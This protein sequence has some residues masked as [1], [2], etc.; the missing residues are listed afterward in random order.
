MQGILHFHN[1]IQSII[2]EFP[3]E[4]TGPASWWVWWRFRLSSGR[5]RR[6]DKRS[7]AFLSFFKHFN[8]GN[9]DH[10]SNRDTTTNTD[11]D[12]LRR[13]KGTERP[14]PGKMELPGSAWASPPLSPPASNVE[15][16]GAPPDE[17]II[18]F[19][20]L[21][22][23]ARGAAASTVRGLVVVVRPEVP[24]SSGVLVKYM[25]NNNKRSNGN[26]SISNGDH[27][28]NTNQTYSDDIGQNTRW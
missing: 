16:G 3:T 17:G 6:R 15:G 21:C 28:S 2:Q 27:R 18:F 20:T 23:G 12:Q 24:F 5:R 14:T 19:S 26:S 7:C 11:R 10:N 13:A 25:T 9:H 1:G 8:N 22:S 4:C